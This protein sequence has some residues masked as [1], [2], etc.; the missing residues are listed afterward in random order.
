MTSTRDDVPPMW[1]PYLAVPNVDEAVTRVRNHGG[2]VH[3][4]PMAVPGVG[5][6]AITADRQGAVLGLITPAPR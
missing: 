6:F 5:R 4:E 1:L 3:A 2:A